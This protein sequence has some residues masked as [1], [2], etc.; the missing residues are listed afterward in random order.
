MNYQCIFCSE[1]C[2]FPATWDEVCEI[3]GKIENSAKNDKHSSPFPHRK[4]AKRN[5]GVLN[6]KIDFRV[7]NSENILLHCFIAN[8]Q[9]G[10]KTFPLSHLD[11]RIYWLWLVREWMS[12]TQSQK[13]KIFLELERYIQF[14]PS[15]Q[16]FTYLHCYTKYPFDDQCLS[17]SDIFLRQV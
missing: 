4:P 9:S 12:I 3:R 6:V 7:K 8:Q 10:I 1:F 2:N 17:C 13:F 5:H 16:G 11:F 15:P 14:M